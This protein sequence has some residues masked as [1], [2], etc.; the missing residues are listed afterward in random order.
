[1]KKTLNYFTFFIALILS[2]CS[3]SDTEKDDNKN[4]LK[5]DNNTIELSEFVTSDEIDSNPKGFYIESYLIPKSVILN[6]L[7][8]DFNGEGYGVS[9]FFYSSKPNFIDP[10]TYKIT[11]NDLQKNEAG[12]ELDYLIDQ[13]SKEEEELIE[14]VIELVKENDKY[15]IKLEAKT[16]KSKKIT[17]YF[18]GNLKILSGC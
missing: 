11:T 17:V 4:I 2:A 13:S 1:M 18:E 12:G 15:T 5:I 6:E 7:E 3:M 9:L 16:E 14:G 10:G 8:C